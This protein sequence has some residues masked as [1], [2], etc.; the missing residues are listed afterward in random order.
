MQ[1][2]P[3]L[4]LELI[5]QILEASFPRGRPRLIADISTDDAQLLVQWARVCRATYA[6]ATRFFRQHCVYLNT[7]GRLRKFLQ[8][9]V[10][11]TSSASS[12]LPPTIPLMSTSSIYI[13]L[14]ME[15][16]Q[17]PQTSSLIRDLFIQLGSSV[18]RL[19]LDLPFRR[20]S[21]DGID[22]HI[23]DLLSDGIAA[24]TNMEEF[25][26]TGGLPTLDFWRRDSDFGQRWPKLRRLAAFQVN[27]AEE[28]LWWNVCRSRTIEEVVIARPYLLRIQKWNVK[29]AI[30][31]HW[32]EEGGDP[33]CARPLK[34]CLVDHEFSPPLLDKTDWELHDP[35]GLMHVSSFDVP[36]AERMLK[37]SDHAC[38]EWLME[39]AKQDS[40]WMH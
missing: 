22:L 33:S 2:S 16:I 14:D 31:A 35:S 34:I 8:C 24:L 26:T 23:N 39:A 4:P 37:R 25:V 13:G 12:T 32:Q 29:Q 38:R 20:L 18:R 27:L 6:P 21:E 15:A 10:A 30:S 17:H 28:G 36:V 1:Q 9:L 40:L 5:L 11:S 3:R 7:V 19:I